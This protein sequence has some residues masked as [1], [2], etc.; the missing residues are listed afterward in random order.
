M[1]VWGA[2][3]KDNAEGYE[4]VYEVGDEETEKTGRGPISSSRKY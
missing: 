2:R 4:E 1:L 3:G